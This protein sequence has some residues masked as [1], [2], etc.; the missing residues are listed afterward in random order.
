MNPKA[1]SFRTG[2][3]KS[4]YDKY[5]QQII[6]LCSKGLSVIEIMDKF[7]EIYEE[8]DSSHLFK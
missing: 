1:K 7:E 4:K 2:I 8:Y 5:E 6:E 3:R